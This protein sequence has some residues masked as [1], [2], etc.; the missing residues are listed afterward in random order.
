NVLKDESSWA[1]FITDEADLA[2]QPDSLKNAMQSAAAER[3]KPDA[4]AVTLARSMVDPFPSFSQ[5]RAL[6]EQALNP[7]AKRGANG[8]ESA[9]RAIGREMVD[10]REGKARLVAS[11]NF[12]A[13]RLADTMAKTAKAVIGRLDPVWDKARAKAREGEVELERLIAGD[14]G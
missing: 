2:G 12:A 7:W 11:A 13:Y 8:G 6:R 5:N 3:G 9:H 14:G 4:W 1:L 10:V